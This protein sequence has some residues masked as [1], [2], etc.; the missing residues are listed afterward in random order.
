[1][2]GRSKRFK[3]SLN[4]PH[5]SLRSRGKRRREGKERE[6]ERIKEREGKGGREDV[7]GKN[8]GG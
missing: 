1:M 8:R 6:K 2:T 3:R 5:T 7:W 4:D